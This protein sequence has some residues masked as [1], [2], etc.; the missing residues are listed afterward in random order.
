MAACRGMSEL[1]VNG[2]GEHC[3]LLLNALLRL[4]EH[5]VFITYCFGEFPSFRE[6]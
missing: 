6:H 3:E 4:P 5:Y 1:S 2:L